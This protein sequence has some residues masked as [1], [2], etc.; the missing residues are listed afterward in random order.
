MPHAPRTP[1]SPV[2]AV[3][4]ILAVLTGAASAVA[5][6][7]ARK[8]A[9]ETR[10]RQPVALLAM[11]DL[12]LV[13][14]RRSGT[15]TLIETTSGAILA[16]HPVAKRIADM[17]SLDDEGRVAVLDDADGELRALSFDAEGSSV[18]PIAIVPRASSKLAVARDRRQVFVSATWSREVVS[19]TFDGGFTA[20]AR[21]ETIELPFAPR[22]L[23]LVDGDRVLLAAD[24]FG[25]RIAVVDAARPR[26]L[27]L[28]RIEAEAQAEALASARRVTELARTRY[29]AGNS[30]YLELVDAERKALEQE[31]R[32]IQLEYQ[33]HAA[34]IGLFKALG[35]A[36][37]GG[38]DEGR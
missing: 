31:R 21:R 28:R 18:R 6:H 27:A 22:E 2:A 25:G 14:N 1:V 23:L 26:V 29:E 20:A 35:G 11:G 38:D 24:A 32:K 15:I 16:E 34:G 8:P 5:E 30:P 12:L 10:L 3:V 17:A 7:P 37:D 13:A 19:I 33:R 4:T 36:W 9:L